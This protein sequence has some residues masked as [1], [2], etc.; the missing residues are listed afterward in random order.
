[1]DIADTRCN[2]RSL[3]APGLHRATCTAS[4]ARSSEVEERQG[5][6]TGRPQ[7]AHRWQHGSNHTVAGAPPNLASTHCLC[8]EYAGCVGHSCATAVLSSSA[9]SAAAGSNV[10]GDS[11]PDD[12][13]HPDPHRDQP[14]D[15]D[16][17]SGYSVAHCPTC[18]CRDLRPARLAE[19][20]ATPGFILMMHSRRGLDH[21]PRARSIRNLLFLSFS[22]SLFFFTYCIIVI[23]VGSQLYLTLHTPRDVLYMLPMRMGG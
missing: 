18:S 23:D 10:I 19:L 3:I 11:D 15:T 6:G 5:P 1:M 4:A 17:R 2:T 21:F 13:R 22:F 20:A 12:R 9:T 7:P 14:G 8:H 16:A